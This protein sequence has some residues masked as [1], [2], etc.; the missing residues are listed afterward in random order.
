MFST[1]TPSTGAGDKGLVGG[2]PMFPSPTKTQ[3]NG[4]DGE[5][6][7]TETRGTTSSEVQIRT[8][9]RSRKRKR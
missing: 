9:V 4:L 5:E 7:G 8:N 2:S 6:L 1:P 3:Y